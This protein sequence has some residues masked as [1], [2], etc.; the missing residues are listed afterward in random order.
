[1]MDAT[2]EIKPSQEPK[3]MYDGFL[4]QEQITTYIFRSCREN[5]EMSLYIWTLYKYFVLK[6]RQMCGV[7]YRTENN[8][9]MTV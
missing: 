8:R 7:T 9:Q 4:T 5:K 1:M 3:K 2:E 6:V